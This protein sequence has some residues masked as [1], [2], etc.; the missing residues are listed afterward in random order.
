M[1]DDFNQILEA[2]KIYGDYY[3]T[4]DIPVD[5]DV[6]AE[7]PWPVYLHG[8]RLGRRLERILS[9]EAF[10]TLHPDKVKLLQSIG[11]NPFVYKQVSSEDWPD[12][13]LAFQSYKSLHGDARVPLRFVVPT[14]MEIWPPNTRGLP[15]GQ[16]ALDIRSTGKFV[17]HR[18]ERREQLDLLDF[19]WKSES[20]GSSKRSAVEEAEQQDFEKLLQG[21][22]VFKQ[23]Q[24]T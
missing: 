12:V 11:F 10:F 21:L 2:I 4:L 19:D 22:Q 9:T 17:K 7:D 13:L 14:N 20:R 24:G 5:F 15:L 3:N 23:Y 6:P 8:L 1:L 16:I 18:P